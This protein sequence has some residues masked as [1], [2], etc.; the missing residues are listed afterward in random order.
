MPL[1]SR[2][3]RLTLR[4]LVPAL[5]VSAMSASGQTARP[6]PEIFQVGQAATASARPGAVTPVVARTCG[7]S[8]LGRGDAE[9]IGAALARWRDEHVAGSQGG[10]I[11][12]AFHVIT[13]RGEG[14]VAD[15]RLQELVQALD[16]SYGVDGYGYRFELAS[17]DRTDRA[18]WLGMT[19]GS[20][21]E[22]KA[23]EALAID[24]ARR[25]NIYVCGLGSGMR[26]WARYP[27]SAPEGD[28]IHGV[29][30]DP[31][32]VTGEMAADIASHEV[33]HYL[34]L[35]DGE[36]EFR[37]FAPVPEMRD[38]VS[39]YRPSLFTAPQAPRAAGTTEIRPG[40]GSEPEDGRVLAYRG[41]VPNPF[42]AETALRFTL[43]TSQQ[44]SL[45]VYSVTGQL[46]R[47]L[48]D[49]TLPPGDHSAMFR[50]GDLPSGAY[51]AVLRAGSVQMTRTLMLIR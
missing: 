9:T 33:G 51:F 34:G 1:T 30:L 16:M 50:A 45:R 7:T 49:A 2:S 20:A 46:V 12:V 14:D 47:T 11:R 35:L 15:A 28:A 42:R 36:I 19:P 23:K 38:V 48:V 25:L 21:K 37:G 41:A 6:A 29:V 26:S 10:T 17:I 39:V 3:G 8:A 4:W 44:V 32:V 18:D 13:V 40:T 22:L 31:G 27:W 24:P 43:P 5:L